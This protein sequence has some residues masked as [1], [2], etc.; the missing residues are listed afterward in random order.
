MHVPRGNV[1]IMVESDP[2]SP[3]CLGAYQA[4][5]PPKHNELWPLPPR[6]DRVLDVPAPVLLKSQEGATA[7]STAAGK[8]RVLRQGPSCSADTA[9]DATRPPEITGGGYGLAL[10]RLKLHRG[11]SLSAPVAISAF[12]QP[13]ASS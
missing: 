5:R 12:C 11:L 6:P 2:P 13:T 7:W 1:T 3:P 9:I 8:V 4:S 10:S